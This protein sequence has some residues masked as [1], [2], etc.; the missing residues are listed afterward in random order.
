MAT[1][2]Q[3]TALPTR[4]L[5]AAVFGSAV[6]AVARVVLDARYPGMFDPAFWIAIDPAVA[7]ALGYFV[8]DE[9]NTP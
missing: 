4:K 5:S 2:K 1:V 7:L 9:D 8:K 6:C 3:P